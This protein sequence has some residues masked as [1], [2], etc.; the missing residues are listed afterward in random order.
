MNINAVL[1]IVLVAVAPTAAFANSNI[2]LDHDVHGRPTEV[3]AFMLQDQGIDA[4]RIE[5]W[6]NAYRVD[7]LDDAGKRYVVI[8]DSNTMLPRAQ[9]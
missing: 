2:D 9:I 8:V 3:V 7:A 1:A 6:G 5:E 4:V